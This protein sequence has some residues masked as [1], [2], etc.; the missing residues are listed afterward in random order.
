M[1][2]R[3]LSIL[4]ASLI[5]GGCAWASAVH[6]QD[7]GPGPMMGG[8]PP[9]AIMIN[10]GPLPPPMMMA[11]RAASL[12]DAQ[13]T[14]IHTLMESSRATVMPLMQQMHTIREQIADK[15]LSP[16]TVTNADLTPLLT[17]QSQIQGQLDSQ[18]VSTA[19]QIRGVL[20]T[21]Q[22]KKVAV[23]NDKLKQIHSEIE[24]IFGPPDASPAP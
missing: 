7:M 19:L 4:I 21:D 5:F 14:Q 10:A 20:T 8:P 16:G 17:Q 12:T 24:S 15:L 13:K 2:K 11:L 1:L 23:A 22:L 3:K 6:A 9:G 18:M